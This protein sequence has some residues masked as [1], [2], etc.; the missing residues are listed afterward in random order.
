ME[1]ILRGQPQVGFGNDPFNPHRDRPLEL[2]GGAGGDDLRREI[3]RTCPRVPGVYGML[4]ARG[5]LIYVGK[6]K[7]LRSR[8]LGYFA[9]SAADD[10]GGRIIEQ[11]RAIQWET[12]PSD[13]AALVREQYLIRRFTP[14]WNVQGVPQRQRPIYL[15]LGRPPAPYFYLSKTRPSDCVA[16]E[17]PFHGAERMGRAVDALNKVFRLRDCSQKQVFRFAEQLQLFELD[18]RPGCLRLE[19]GTCLGPCAGGC[20]RASYEA[21]VRAAARF[22]DGFQGE[23]VEA[24]ERQMDEASANRQYELAGRARDTLKSLQYVQRKLD[25]LARARRDY[26]FIYA[27]SAYDGCGTWYLVCHGEIADVAA[28]PR[29]PDD[30]A[31]LK[32]VLQRWTA[33]L[34]GAASRYQGDHPHTVALVAAWFRKHRRELDRTFQP[35]EAGRKYFRRGVTALAG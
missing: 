24:V 21:Q 15:C 31:A 29:N 8:L 14:R 30:Y 22:L 5:E 28:A 16:V 12:Q 33:M 17:G 11:T 13:F 19:I 6:S 32:P 25:L 23:P 20:D 35:V 7:S 1:A 18:E 34:E 9:D 4:D 10:K 3:A 27:A 2:V 26:S